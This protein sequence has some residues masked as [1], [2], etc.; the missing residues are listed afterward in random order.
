MVH[1][2]I[3]R[4]S[5]RVCTGTHTRIGKKKCVQD[6]EYRKG[7]KNDTCAG[8]STHNNGA[9]VD[10]KLG[11]REDDT[12]TRAHTHISLYVYL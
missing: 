6:R 8:Q 1:S 12:H 9:A 4:W 10:H 2:Y 3:L 5:R 11:V 7:H